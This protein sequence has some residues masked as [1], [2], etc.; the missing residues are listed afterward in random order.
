MA[1]REVGARDQAARHVEAG[2]IRVGVGG[3]TY[4]PWRSTFYPPDVPRKRELEYASRQLTTIEIN[5]TYY[6]LQTPASYAKWRDAT[7]DEFVFAVKAPRYA[8]NR[9]VLAEAKQSIAL[10]FKS[11]LAELGDK[12]GPVL[13]QFAPTKQFAPLDFERFLDLL[14]PRAGSRPLRH[15]L[16]VRH[17][18]FMTGEF[19]GLANRYGVA[20]V[21]ADT[22]EYPSFADV[23]ADFVYARL[24]RCAAPVKTG[25]TSRALTTWAQRA[26]VWA[27]GGEPNDLPRVRQDTAESVPRDV[28]IYFISG[29]KERAPAAARA[30]L[31]RL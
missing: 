1:A 2:N 15:V 9:K 30:L 6:R 13:W 12:L 28:F 5:G 16:D 14:P 26:H 31:S 7:P 24:M 3:W 27:Q 25:Y 17:E 22:D 8:T 20:V 18:S 19:L 29:A 10:F 21:F 4:E 23:T 11:G